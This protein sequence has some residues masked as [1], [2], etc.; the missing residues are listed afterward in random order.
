[1]SN[2]SWR[3]RGCQIS[4]AAITCCFVERLQPLA[5]LASQF[6]EIQRLCRTAGF[7]FIPDLA[8]ALD[9]F[10]AHLLL[11]LPIAERLADNLAGGRVLAGLD[12]RLERLDLLSGER[13]TDFTDIGHGTSPNLLVQF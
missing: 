10:L 9:V 2:K 1:M 3:A 12:R 11:Q 13:D 5:R 8:Q 4:L 7:A 6:S